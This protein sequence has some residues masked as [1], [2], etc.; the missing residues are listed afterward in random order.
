VNYSITQI[1]ILFSSNIELL[2]FCCHR[3]WWIQE[4]IK[5]GAAKRRLIFFRLN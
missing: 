2:M 4:W 1:N 3:Q 5:G